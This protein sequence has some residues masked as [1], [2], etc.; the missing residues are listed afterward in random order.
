MRRFGETNETGAVWRSRPGLANRLPPVFR[1]SRPGAA[2]RVATAAK[3]FGCRHRHSPGGDRRQRREGSPSHP[4]AQA[5]GSGFRSPATG[6]RPPATDYRTPPPA[7]RSPATG[8]RQQATGYRPLP[9]GNRFLTRRRRERGAEKQKP[10]IAT[11]RRDK[12]R[13]R[14]SLFVSLRAFLWPWIGGAKD[15]NPWRVSLRR[16]TDQTVAGMRFGL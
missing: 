5:R 15:R 7:H 16:E 1:K 8:Y 13:E 6:N 9:T 12:P 2:P 3:A 4:R 14:A 11:K 10:G